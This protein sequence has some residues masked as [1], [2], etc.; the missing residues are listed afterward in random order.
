MKQLTSYNRVAIQ[1]TP[2]AYAHFSHRDDWFPL[3]EPPRRGT[4]WGL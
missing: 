4:G 3:S 1:S 2:K